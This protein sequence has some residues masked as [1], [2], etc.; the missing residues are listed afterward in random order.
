MTYKPRLLPTV[1]ALLEQRRG[2]WPS[3]QRE[4][5]IVSGPRVD[6][7]EALYQYLT[8]VDGSAA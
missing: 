7:V 8:S 5:G 6:T 4:T 3:I 1:R 2:E